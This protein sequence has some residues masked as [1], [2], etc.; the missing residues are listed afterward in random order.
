MQAPLASMMAG[1]LDLLARID[2]PESLLRHPAVEAGTEDSAPGSGA[3][4]HRAEHAALQPGDYLGACIRLRLQRDQ[5]VLLLRLHQRGAAAGQHRV[6]NPAFRTFPI[7]DAAPVLR[8]GRDLDGQASAGINP[9]DVMITGR[10]AADIHPIGL[11]AHEARNREAA[12][13]TSGELACR[14]SATPG[15]TPERAP[16]RAP[17]PTCGLQVR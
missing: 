9:G 3:G 15:H 4:L 8:L 11:Q 14:M 6:I 13:G 2:A 12:A 16:Q 1:L 10:T 17:E 5:R 7:A